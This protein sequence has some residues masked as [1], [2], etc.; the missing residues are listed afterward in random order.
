MTRCIV[1]GEP[2]GASTSP[3]RDVLAAVADVE[4]AGERPAGVT[5]PSSTAASSTRRIASAPSGSAAPVVMPSAVPGASASAATS[6]AATSPAHRERRG[7]VGVGRAH[8]VAVHRGAVERRQVD[9]AARVLGGD[10]AV[11]SAS[12]TRSTGSG[13]RGRRD[14]LPGLADLEQR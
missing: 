3:R 4:A 8:R 12:G 6:P 7:R 10:P 5:R 1:S 13:C 2:A 11:A 9:G 14:A